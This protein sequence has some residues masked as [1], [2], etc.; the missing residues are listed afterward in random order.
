MVL[1]TTIFLATQ[2][3]YLSIKKEASSRILISLSRDLSILTTALTV[4]SSLSYTQQ[5]SI[6]SSSASL[7]T[8]STALFDIIQ[9]LSIK[10]KTEFIMTTPPKQ[11]SLKTL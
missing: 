7:E 1:L 3:S 9:I 2:K 6:A 5:R 11:I 4:I 10:F 8:A